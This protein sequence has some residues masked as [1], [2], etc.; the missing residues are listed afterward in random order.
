[1][2]T[3]KGILHKKDFVDENG[4][5]YPMNIEMLKDYNLKA[6]ILCK[7]VDNVL[8]VYKIQGLLGFEG[9]L[10]PTQE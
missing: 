9:P 1:M 7:M 10:T 3:L 8:K 5:C 4:V 2:L 6:F